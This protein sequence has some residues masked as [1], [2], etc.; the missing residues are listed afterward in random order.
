MLLITRLHLLLHTQEY[1]HKLVVCFELNS[2][3]KVSMLPKE[4]SLVNSTLTLVM[5]T[6]MLTSCAEGSSGKNATVRR[7]PARG[8]EVVQLSW[9]SDAR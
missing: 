7:A 3:A 9:G 1:M 4:P 8:A 6:L 5:T 2:L